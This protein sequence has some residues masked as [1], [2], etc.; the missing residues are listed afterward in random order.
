VDL[1][2]R[3]IRV[4]RSGQRKMTKGG[5]EDIP[6]ASELLPFL[7]AA[8]DASPSELVFPGPEG[9]MMREDVKLQAVLRRAMA[10]AGIV[11]GYEHRCRKHG[12]KHREKQPDN[13]PRRC[14]G[15]DVLLWPVPLVRRIRFH[16]LRHSTA[17]NLMP[18]GVS[19]P[20]VQRVMRHC[21]PRLTMEVYGHLSP[22][23]VLREIDKL[24][25]G[26]A[27]ESAEAAP[28]EE[29]L[30][31]PLL[32]ASG[33][34]SKTPAAS[35]E[36]ASAAEALSRAGDGG[37]TRDPRLGKRSSG[38]SS[39]PTGSHAVRSTRSSWGLSTA[40]DLAS[41]PLGPSV[42]PSP[43]PFASP[44]ASGV[45]G[46]VTA[47]LVAA[48]LLTVPEVAEQ[49]RV[50]PVTVYRL[51][52]RGALPHLRVSNSIRIRPE[53]LEGFIRRASRGGPS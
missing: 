27:P 5:H 44:L 47:R 2:A 51:C 26:I 16:E 14:P 21:D 25:L 52:E 9:R 48:A 30:L 10:R 42:P 38:D 43:L 41:V 45:G 53:D 32:Q 22:D 31:H 8:I 35:P 36:I 50:R 23:Y 18:A 17:S 12:C 4:A 33:E 11:L 29:S 46:P 40:Q 3:S 24:K 13:S 28:S 1:D 39:D 7:K 49:L 20:V 34:D 15:H 6:I 19:V 37:R